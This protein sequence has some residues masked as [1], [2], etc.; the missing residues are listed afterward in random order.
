MRRFTILFLEFLL[1]EPLVPVP[2]LGE[3]L[4]AE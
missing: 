2:Y 3:A 1:R 4:T